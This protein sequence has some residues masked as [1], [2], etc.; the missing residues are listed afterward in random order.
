MGFAVTGML[1]VLSEVSAFWSVMLTRSGIFFSSAPEETIS[2]TVEPT[3]TVRPG[4]GDW[5]RM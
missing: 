3:L 1:I 4:A 2:P 5:S